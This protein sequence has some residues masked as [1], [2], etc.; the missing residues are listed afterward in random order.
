MGGDLGH[1]ERGAMQKPFS[2]AA[3]ALQVD[4]VSG[5]VDT[6][7]GVHIIQRIE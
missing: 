5:I 6:E 3:F 1:F 2:D 4:E 7:S